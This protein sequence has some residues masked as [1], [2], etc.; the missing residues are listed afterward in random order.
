VPVADVDTVALEVA[1][2]L[3]TGPTVSLGLTKWLLQTAVEHTLDQH[4]RAEAFAMELSSRSED[5]R[6]GLSA[7]VEKRDP[8]FRGR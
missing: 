5:F 4:L 6:E 2:Q 1:Q 7:F 3:A 8:G